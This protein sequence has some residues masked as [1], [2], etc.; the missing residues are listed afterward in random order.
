MKVRYSLVL[1]AAIILV[2]SIISTNK[3]I[4]D[5]VIT[6]NKYE[7]FYVKSNDLNTMD[8]LVGITSSNDEVTILDLNGF[9]SIYYDYHSS[10][11]FLYLER[12][13]EGCEYKNALYQINLLNESLKLE[14]I[15]DLKDNVYNPLRGDLQI[16]DNYLYFSS[17]QSDFIL[18][19]DLSN[20]K[21]EETSINSDKG[22]FVI[23]KSK[24]LLLYTINDKIYEYNLSLNKNNLLFDNARIVFLKSDKLIYSE[25]PYEKNN[26]ILRE[27]SYITNKTRRISF[28]NPNGVN[29]N[30]LSSILPLNN[31]YIYI[32]HQSFINTIDSTN[33]IDNLV[34]LE[35][36]P[37]AI[38]HI[39]D[40]Y[41]W[42]YEYCTDCNNNV[43]INLKTKEI[44]PYD[45]IIGKVRY[46]K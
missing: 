31:S 13:C 46:V 41:I 3:T 16:Y 44:K 27:Y 42:A 15:L 4:R 12:S 2:A 25:W 28:D 23:N 9:K 19:M 30:S 17:N 45:Y 7:Y 29:I 11:V 22:S 39:N 40:N 21:I 6:K 43:I 5:I 34:Q 24:G 18:K 10:N 38:M 1:G 37:D 8:S 36:M 33:K 26:S 20:N 14:L 32:S 35:F